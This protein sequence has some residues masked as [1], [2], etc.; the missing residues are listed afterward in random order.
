VGQNHASTDFPVYCPKVFA[1]IGPAD[2][3]LGDRCLPN[4]IER[5]TK[6]ERRRLGLKRYR[7]R[8][9]KA[10]LEALHGEL[11]IW[12]AENKERVREIY[13]GVDGAGLEPFDV[14]NDR[15]AD[16][17]TPLQAVLIA[18][19]GQDSPLLDILKTYA[20]GVDEQARQAE[21]PTDGVRLLFALY[22]IFHNA[23]IAGATG[24]PPWEGIS[25]DTLIA[26]L[27]E[28]KDEKWAT[29]RRDKDPI[30]R[31]AMASLLRPYGIKSQF[32][33]EKTG[34]FY[35]RG[36]FKDA[37]ERYCHLPGTEIPSSPSNP[38]I[39]SNGRPEGLEGLEGLEG[40]SGGGPGEHAPTGGAAAQGGKGLAARIAA[41]WAEQAAGVTDAEQT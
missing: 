39:L 36:R 2:L 33:K 7:Y 29:Y 35:Y 22:D 5:V 4:L 32:N 21:G 34:K 20:E 19:G 25:P 14:E 18:V 8:A 3:V 40:F 11:C 16:L 30:T 1:H 26:K 41:M 23:V 27:V 6:E 12:A 31:E 10:A 13:D 17:L 37:W 24:R 38:S 9:V 28:R 15:L